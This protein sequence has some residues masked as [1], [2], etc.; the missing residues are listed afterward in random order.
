MGT[1]RVDF[2]LAATLAGD[3]SPRFSQGDRVEVIDRQCTAFGQ[4]GRVHMFAPTIAFPTRYV[5]RLGSESVTWFLAEAQIAAAFKFEVNAQCVLPSGL[6]CIIATRDR[7][8]ARGGNFYAVR[9]DHHA[10]FWWKRASCH[11]RKWRVLPAPTI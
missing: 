3:H 10:W 6:R 7:S 11:R 5:V 4:T 8:P 2:D 9:I 1:V